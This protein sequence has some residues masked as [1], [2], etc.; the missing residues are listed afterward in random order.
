MAADLAKEA[1]RYEEVT[2]Y[3]S[4]FWRDHSKETVYERPP[5]PEVDAAW[6]RL[7]AGKSRTPRIGNRGGSQWQW[8]CTLSP[9]KSTSTSDSKPALCRET[10]RNMSLHWRFSI[11][12]TAWYVLTLSSRRRNANHRTWQNYLRQRVYGV[13]MDEGSEK[14]KKAH[15]GMESAIRTSTILLT[16]SRYSALRGLFTAS[17][18]VPRR[19]DADNAHLQQGAQLCRPQLP[20]QAYVPKL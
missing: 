9:L 8:A 11:S 7:I 16:G 13:E 14:G 19:S 12:S 17:S 6:S 15:L 10:R 2:F 18:D 3:P 4:G 20:H 5:G 1:I